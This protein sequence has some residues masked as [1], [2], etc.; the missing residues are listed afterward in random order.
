MS[1]PLDYGELNNLADLD[2]TI[3]G[4]VSQYSS[5]DKRLACLVLGVVPIWDAEF[6]LV[7]L[8]SPDKAPLM[9]RMLET[10]SP[11]TKGNQ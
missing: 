5:A 3:D 2:V 7:C 8:C 4:D 9:K 1:D 10:Y 6:E 11:V